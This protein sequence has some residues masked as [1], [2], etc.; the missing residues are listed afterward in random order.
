MKGARP[1]CIIVQK[2]L[3]RD[4]AV[5]AYKVGDKP[6]EFKPEDWDRV[7]TVFVFGK[8]W[9]FKDWPYK[10]HVEIFNKN[11]TRIVGSGD[12]HAETMKELL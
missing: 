7:V 11:I 12:L 4:R 9:Q 10:D 1:D 5:T 6:S 2:K 8:D 3:S